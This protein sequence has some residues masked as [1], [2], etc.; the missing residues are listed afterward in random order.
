MKIHK[1]PAV[2]VYYSAKFVLG[3]FVCDFLLVKLAPVI[4]TRHK[5]TRLLFP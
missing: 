5:M 2:A 3:N 1:T 4:V